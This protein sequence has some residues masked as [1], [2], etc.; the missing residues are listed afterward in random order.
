MCDGVNFKFLFIRI[1]FHVRAVGVEHITT[2]QFMRNGLMHYL[3]K[4]MLLDIRCL[5]T[6]A[7]LLAKRGG[8]DNFIGQTHPQK[9]AVSHVNLHFAHELALAAH[10]KK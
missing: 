5:K 1:R 6:T 8:I 9:T 10:T 7:A 3:I 4:N 2:H